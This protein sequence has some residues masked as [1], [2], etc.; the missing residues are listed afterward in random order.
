MKASTSS[1]SSVVL[2]NKINLSQQVSLGVKQQI[3]KGIYRPG[4]FLP[5]Y[6]LLCSE[7][8]VS[9][10]VIY[11]AIRELESSGIV[12]TQ[13]GRG[14]QVS[15]SRQ[16][17]RAAI[18]FGFIQP[19]P[20]DVGFQQHVL[21]YAA[22]SFSEHNNFVVVQSAMA[23]VV[24]ER[25][26]AEHFVNNGIQGIMLWPVEKSTNRAFFEQLSSKVPVV[27]V[28]RLFTDS[29]L[30]GVVLDTYGAGRD[31]C[32]ETFG[33]LEHRR[34]LVLMDD[35]D[36]STYHELERGVRETAETIGRGADLVVKRLAL[37]PIIRQ[38]NRCDFSQ[39]DGLA[40]QIG[41][42][43]RDYQCDALFCMQDEILDNAV[44][45]T[46]LYDELPGLQLLTTAAGINVRTR[47]YNEIGVVKWQVDYP[48]MI[49]T[50][51]EMLQQIVVGRKKTEEVIRLK[52]GRCQP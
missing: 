42:W 9:L 4:D 13:H 24:R 21:Q 2:G 3:R 43:L 52:V 32:R 10:N 51:T 37:S 38:M 27:Q 20:A 6:R 7:F 29:K 36:I 44:V 15:V 48:A 14:A 22:Q 46:G 8:K 45:Q 11:R 19:Y 40:Q 17:E 49:T 1:S 35:L 12:S 50:A 25:Q 39:V 33:R 16:V 28:D 23:S 47:K 34:L 31:I 26:I 5:S 30:P 41:A 18:L